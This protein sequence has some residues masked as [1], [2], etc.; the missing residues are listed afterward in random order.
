MANTTVLVLIMAIVGLLTVPSSGDQPEMAVKTMMMDQAET[1]ENRFIRDSP[2]VLLEGKESKMETPSMLRGPIPPI[3][4]VHTASVHYTSRMDPDGT[5][6]YRRDITVPCDYGMLLF[7]VGPAEDNLPYDYD[8]YGD[9][10]LWSDNN[11]LCILWPTYRGFQESKAG[12][13][14]KL[15]YDPMTVNFGNLEPPFDSMHRISSRILDPAHAQNHSHA[16]DDNRAGDYIIVAH[17]NFY[18]INYY[19][20]LKAFVNAWKPTPTATTTGVTEEK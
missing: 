11:G 19:K 8:I 7:N 9:V 2:L 1:E 13:F 5:T 20:Q 3:H 17:H 16:I 15:G 12:P 14:W 10:Y 6:T 18:D 4:P